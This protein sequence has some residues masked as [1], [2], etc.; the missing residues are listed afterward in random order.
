[1]RPFRAERGAALMYALLVVFILSLIV[2][3]MTGLITSHVKEEENAF[4]YSHL[5]YSAEAAVNWQLLQVSR[6]VPNLPDGSKPSNPGTGFL[7]VDQIRQVQPDTRDSSTANNAEINADLGGIQLR[8]DVH[9]WVKN[10]VSGATG[11]WQPP[12]DCIVYAVATDPKTGYRRG[13]SLVA[14]GTR[15]E[16]RYTLFGRDSL[17]FTANAGGSST[18]E[19]GYIGSN[20]SVSYSGAA[21]QSFNGSL[22]GLQG[23]L[24]NGIKASFDSAAP[25]GWDIP[26]T[27]DA[28]VFPPI[29]EI[30]SYIFPGTDISTL[31]TDP[32]TRN[33]QAARS[34]KIYAERDGS[35]LLP[36]G[37]GA[38]PYPAIGAM[39]H[40]NYRASLK[41]FN[42]TQFKTLGPVTS[43]TEKEFA[44][45]ILPKSSDA[46][47]TP[48]DDPSSP[49]YYPWP[50]NP[51]TGQPLRVIR[52]HSY[53]SAVTD[54]TDQ[55][56][57]VFYFNNIQM[58]E[59]DVLLLDMIRTTD[60]VGAPVTC[61]IVVHGNLNQPIHIT[62]VAVIQDT[63]ADTAH[64][65]KK[66]N[67]IASS[68]V[69]Y[70]D[71][72][73]PM[74]FKPTFTL[75]A[76]NNAFYDSTKDTLS[77]DYYKNAPQDTHFPNIEFLLTPGCP[78]M[79]YGIRP[80]NTSLPV[81]GV[82]NGGAIVID[83][84][85]VP[86]TVV[87]AIANKVTLTGNVTVGQ[88]TAKYV[89]SYYNYV[90]KPT[91]TYDLTRSTV[92]EDTNDP[93]Y[94]VY[95]YRVSSQ[96]REINPDNPILQTEPAS[97]YGKAPF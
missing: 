11:P 2:L 21:P 70:N 18:I 73:Q 55:D 71:T 45:S 13:V 54:A 86:C 95:F 92:I 48:P 50:K 9:T 40:M 7:T 16:D 30:V 65:Y 91:L 29:S 35:D 94:L 41:T 39:K 66:S 90:G 47:F 51:N 85:R 75:P 97:E 24:Q 36:D 79:A 12:Q 80:P 67:H 59:N 81:G 87:A 57:N 42:S 5:I 14:S 15:L 33:N 83:G 22:G 62:N 49:D 25:S 64:G 26:R 43:L 63:V 74:I 78:G 89:D 6:V 4:E 34:Q 84:S 61:R 10:G 19:R 76:V 17:T 68:F 38:Y 56:M 3:A 58:K 60:M 28:A 69:F 96:Y 32:R 52:L 31:Q 37:R 77:V 8:D 27:T 88:T 72:N 23:C 46:D 1:M 82:D 44:K 20:G 53:V 93:F